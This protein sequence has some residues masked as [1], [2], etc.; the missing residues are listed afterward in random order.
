MLD[1][2]NFGFIVFLSC[3]FCVAI[4]GVI[5]SMKKSNSLFDKNNNIFYSFFINFN[6]SKNGLRGVYYKKRIAYISL[7]IIY[8]ICLSLFFYNLMFHFVLTW[9]M[10]DFFEKHITSKFLRTIIYFFYNRK[11]VWFLIFFLIFFFYKKRI[12][13]LKKFICPVCLKTIFTKEF[14][15]LCPFCDRN[16]GNKEYSIF[17]RHRSCGSKLKFVQCPKCNA[18]IDLFRPYDEDLFERRRY[19]RT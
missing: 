12:V 11:E 17:K 8:S 13:Y 4:W 19:G 16:I 18:E 14:N 1:N 10:L 15:I 6:S 7:R 2:D 5:D 3:I 9:P